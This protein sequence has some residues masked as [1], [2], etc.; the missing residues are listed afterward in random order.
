MRARLSLAASAVLF[1]VS[2][3]AADTVPCER[4]LKHLNCQEIKDLAKRKNCEIV[5][6][7]CV[8]G[9][10]GAPGAQEPKGDIGPT[11]PQGLQGDKVWLE[12]DPAPPP[13]EHIRPLLGFGLGYDEYHYVIGHV[14]SGMQ[15]PKDR[16]GHN[17]QLQIGPTYSHRD[18]Y[19]STAG[20]PHS[21]NSPPDDGFEVV[22]PPNWGV[23][24]S[25]VVV[26]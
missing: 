20:K 7:Q 25:G 18:V 5:E 6:V 13:R 23:A 2:V 21:H 17:W 22:D 3:M 10:Q 16:Y 24:V 9:K 15:F 4:P 14:F 26:F 12:H 8:E 19:R 11:G 1:G